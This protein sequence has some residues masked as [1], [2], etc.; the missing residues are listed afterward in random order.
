MSLWQAG[1]CTVR[2]NVLLNS[3]RVLMKVI[4][5]RSDILDL[6]KNTPRR[7]RFTWHKM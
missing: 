5:L 7:M 3:T 1:P 2:I 4:G 6:T